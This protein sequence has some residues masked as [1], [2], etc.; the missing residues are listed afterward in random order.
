MFEVGEQ[1]FGGKFTQFHSIVIPQLCHVT[2]V[3]HIA[4]ILKL[5]W[6]TG[7]W[8]MWLTHKP[9]PGL[10]FQTTS[11]LYSSFFYVLLTTDGLYSSFS[12]L[13]YHFIYIANWFFM[14][15]T[16]K[17]IIYFAVYLLILW[18]SMNFQNWFYFWFTF[19]KENFPFKIVFSRTEHKMC[20]S[21]F[22]TLWHQ[23][24]DCWTF[25]CLTC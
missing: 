25:M 3:S 13:F 10:A 4:Q 11:F 9:K 7:I 8:A 21:F 20:S 23:I 24:L 2:F 17:W 12:H 16:S 1:R 5:Q 18:K 22:V 6:Q 19:T 14:I 15:S